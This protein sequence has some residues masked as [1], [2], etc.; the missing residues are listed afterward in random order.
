MVRFLD[1]IKITD[2][3]AGDAG[4]NV[5]GS[6]NSCGSDASAGATLA[7]EGAWVAGLNGD[8]VVN[9]GDAGLMLASG[10]PVLPGVPRT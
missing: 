3:E 5:C 9:G 8:G 1:C 4:T 10:W 2:L 6:H 7:I